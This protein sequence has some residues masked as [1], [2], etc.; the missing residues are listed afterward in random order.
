MPVNESNHEDKLY[1]GMGKLKM[2][3]IYSEKAWGMA[4]TERERWIEHED[5]MK[6]TTQCDQA[7]PPGRRCIGSWKRRPA[8]NT[9]RTK[10]TNCVP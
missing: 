8:R 5:K 1:S 6:L 10:M 4:P 2:L 3:V 9:L 7:R